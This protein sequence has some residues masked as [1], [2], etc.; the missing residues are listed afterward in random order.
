[1]P[2]LDRAVTILL[3]LGHKAKLSF[4]GHCT[5]MSQVRQIPLNK[6][7]RVAMGHI[8]KRLSSPNSTHII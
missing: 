4:R 8:D 6:K 1:M 5:E 2:C 7:L 3:D